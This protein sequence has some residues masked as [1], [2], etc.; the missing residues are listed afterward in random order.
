M[1]E[2]INLNRFCV[3]HGS[4]NFRTVPQPR[5]RWRVSFDR[6]GERLAPTKVV[7]VD[8]GGTLGPGKLRKATER[9]TVPLRVKLLKLLD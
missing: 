2:L 8:F 3:G 1:A 9:E 7:G 5:Q 4:L 6:H